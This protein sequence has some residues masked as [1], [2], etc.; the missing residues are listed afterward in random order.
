MTEVTCDCFN[1]EEK[2]FISGRIE[3]INC[4]FCIN[5][6]CTAENLDLGFDG[7]YWSIDC[8][9]KANKLGD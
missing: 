8:P 3:V 2:K 6:K 5:G 4:P 9:K 1:R 7:E